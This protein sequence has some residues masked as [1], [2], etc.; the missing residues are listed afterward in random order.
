MP[1]ENSQRISPIAQST[2]ILLLTICSGTMLIYRLIKIIN[3]DPAPLTFMVNRATAGQLSAWLL[4]IGTAGWGAFSICRFV[5]SAAIR[6]I[7]DRRQAYEQVLAVAAVCTLTAGLGTGQ[8]FYTLI[9]A[10]GL[11]FLAGGPSRRGG[12]TPSPHTLTA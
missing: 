1:N 6:S 3:L 8:L 4:I 5:A 7:A 12:K 2:W 9:A 11:A 10:A